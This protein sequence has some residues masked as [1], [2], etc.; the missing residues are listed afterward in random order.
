MASFFSD[1]GKQIQNAAKSVQKMTKDSLE[2]TRLNGEIRALRDEQKKLLTTLG[3]A[4]YESRGQMQS[5]EQLDLIVKRIDE[6]NER[7]KAISAE[8]DALSDKK[9]CPSCD[10]L[11]AKDVKFYSSCGAKQ[12]ERAPEPE[13]PEPASEAE[14]EKPDAEFCTECGALR[15]DDG[16]FCVVCGHAFSAPDVEKPEVEIT[17]PEAGAD[18]AEPDDAPSEEPPAEEEH[19]EE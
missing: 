6:I 16:R 10:A 1:L 17:W 5:A 9:R 18:D 19:T 11:L 4:Y 3:E 15:Q 12:P 2:A 13:A 14:P 8:L 7:A